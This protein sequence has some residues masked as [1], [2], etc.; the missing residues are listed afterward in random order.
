[1]DYC[2]V[3]QPS[4]LRLSVTIDSLGVVRQCACVISGTAANQLKII[5]Q[6]TFIDNS[7]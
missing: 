2:S 3:V 4:Q 5:L 7:K 1:M 6:I